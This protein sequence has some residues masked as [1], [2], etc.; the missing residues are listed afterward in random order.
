MKSHVCTVCKSDMKPKRQMPGSILIE[1][2]LWCFFLIPGLIYSL[3][4]IS[5][6][7]KACPCCGA[8]TFVKSNTDVGKDLIKQRQLLRTQTS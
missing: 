5:S 3:W 7:K 6:A 1:L 4:R 2:V 8:F